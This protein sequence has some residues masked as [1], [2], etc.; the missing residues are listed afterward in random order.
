MVSGE[1]SEEE[2][3]ETQ[4]INK[5]N[6]REIAQAKQ[7]QGEILTGEDEEEEEEVS[8]LQHTRE[9]SAQEDQKETK[10]LDEYDN[11]SEKPFQAQGEKVRKEIKEMKSHESEIEFDEV[12]ST[13]RR[14]FVHQNGADLLSSLTIETIVPRM[15]HLN[16]RLIELIEAQN[17]IRKQIE[18]ECIRINSNSS[19]QKVQTTIATAG[20][21]QMKLGSLSRKMFQIQQQTNRMKIQALNLRQKTE[22]LN[23]KQIAEQVADQ[24]MV[25]QPSAQLQ[26]QTKEQKD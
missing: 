1:D 8:V 18:R 20:I 11:G 21:Y 3:E 14:D 2:N 16:D 10:K 19:L 17:Q 9:N 26:S 24:K 4:E 13:L 22:Q 5:E 7:V 23:A 25:A 15:K 6:T 12:S